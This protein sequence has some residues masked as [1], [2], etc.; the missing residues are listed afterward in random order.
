MF[1][2]IIRGFCRLILFVVYRIKVQGS[3]NIPATGKA[4]I[5]ANHKSYLDPAI[6]ACGIKRKIY[7]MAKAEL[8]SLPVLGKIIKWSGA[9]PVK[10]G[11]A[12]IHSIK[13][14]LDLL[15]AENLV[16]IF[17]EGGRVRGEKQLKVKP[18]AA[19]LALKSGAPII[20]AAI[21][22][23]S[24]LF[25]RINLTIGKPYRFD[26]TNNDKASIAELQ[27]ISEIIMQKIK[28]LSDNI[29]E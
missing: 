1:Y 7:F 20:P 21:T 4:I 14:A 23:K 13:S 18:G 5:C 16:G 17:P 28:Q 10:R 11:K 22:G 15:E 12:D 9:F 26:T 25:S 6:L 3:E 8:F 27:K 29:P 24:T 2:W 19:L